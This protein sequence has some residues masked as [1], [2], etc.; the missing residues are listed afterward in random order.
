MPV[1]SKKSFV[2]VIVFL[3]YYFAAECHVCPFR[4]FYHSNGILLNK[5]AG[6]IANKTENVFANKKPIIYD[7]HNNICG[8]NIVSDEYGKKNY[9]YYS[10]IDNHYLFFY[11]LVF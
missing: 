8:S 1:F 4:T 2:C 10:I 11:L 7:F 9:N 6:I 3:T 5:N